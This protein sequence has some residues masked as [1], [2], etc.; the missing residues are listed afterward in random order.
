MNISSLQALWDGFSSQK[1]PAA[2][3]AG[4]IFAPGYGTAEAVPFQRLFLAATRNPNAIALSQ[5]SFCGVTHRGERL[6]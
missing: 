5:V 4:P 3:K 6:H 1:H 2:A